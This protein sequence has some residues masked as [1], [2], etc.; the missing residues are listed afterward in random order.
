MDFRNRIA[1]IFAPSEIEEF[2]FAIAQFLSLVKLSGGDG[3][4]ESL[5][6][7]LLLVQLEL[8]KRVNNY[9]I[10]TYGDSGS[11]PL[12]STNWDIV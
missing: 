12:D 2:A 6:F 9:I 11:N 5:P 8:T 1:N 3:N 10:G 7:M 4:V